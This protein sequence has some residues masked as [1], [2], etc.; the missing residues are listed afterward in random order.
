[1]DRRQFLIGTMA[2][3][4]SVHVP[5]V[6]AS[7]YQFSRD[8]FTLGIASGD[9]SDDAVVLWTRLAPEPLAEYGGVGPVAVP[10]RWE[11]ARD[12]LMSE[13]IQRGESLAE[14]GF[15]HSVH[16]DVRRLEPNTEYWYRFNIGDWTSQTGRT[17]TLPARS[18]HTS[19]VRF[20]TTSCQN[21]THGEFLAY[22]HIIAEQPDFVIHL[23]DYIYDTSFGESYRQHESEEVPV[24]LEAFRQRHA[25]YKTDQQLQRAHAA[26]PFFT[27][28]DNHDATEDRDPSE[29]LRR[30]AA[31]QAWYEHMPVRGYRAPGDN[32][33]DLKRLINLGDLA[34]ISLLDT[35]QFRDKKDLCGDTSDTNIGFG[36]YQA[37]C[38]DLFDDSRTM[39][40]KA[41]EDW[42]S[43][44]L[45]KNKAA[46]NVIASS[47]PIL[48]FRIHIDETEYGYIGAWDAYPAN[49][50]RL[51]D[52]LSRATK[53][54]PLVLSGDM[55]SFWALDGEL[56]PQADERI[57]LVEFVSSSISANWPEPLSRPVRENLVRNPQIQLY[58]GE[59]RGYL[60]HNVTH[61]QWQTTY[62]AVETVKETTSSVFDLETF[63][64]KH[65]EPGMQT[66]D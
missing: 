53:G 27:I 2:G 52:A 18:R 22:E 48:P 40:G 26:L 51:V 55:H 7:D 15:A 57:P 38:D 20:V 10:V 58:D 12:A 62:R 33:F 21:Y 61:D 37:R 13:V 14:P 23:G 25:L 17:K 47:G 5:K 35:R 44:N 54:H 46:W 63:V 39:L 8:P 1:M 11:L 56:F 31:Y 4:A 29:S 32:Y 34:Q 6:V 49:R 16:I 3:I 45:I 41:Q 64:L 19:S 30:A 9:I 65:G 43:E 28:V 59:H 24:T 66:L 50:A 60:V 42:L 36:N